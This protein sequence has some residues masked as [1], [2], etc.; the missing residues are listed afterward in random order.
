MKDGR[1]VAWCDP[2]VQECMDAFPNGFST[3][4]YCWS[5]DA[6]DKPLGPNDGFEFGPTTYK[7]NGQGPYSYDQACIHLS[8]GVDKGVMF[9]QNLGAW[10][11]LDDCF[12]TDALSPQDLAGWAGLH[13]SALFDSGM[14][15]LYDANAG[16]SFS[17]PDNQVIEWE[18]CWTDADVQGTALPS[19]CNGIALGPLAISLLL[20]V[21]PPSSP[22]PSSSSSLSRKP[23]GP[24]IPSPIPSAASSQ[25]IS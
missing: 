6:G 14:I 3:G 23:S 16:G 11:C 7:Y 21:A 13:A 25:F 9:D 5:Q 15:Q 1:W 2:D 22:L 17:S 10:R 24:S 19:G 12:P 8:C 20:R 18:A 4:W